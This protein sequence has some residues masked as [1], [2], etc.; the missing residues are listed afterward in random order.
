MFLGV[1]RREGRPIEVAAR[2][3][4]CLTANLGVV[5]MPAMQMLFAS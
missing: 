2:P 5:P 4:P 3:V 1:G